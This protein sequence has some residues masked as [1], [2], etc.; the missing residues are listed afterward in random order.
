MQ[1]FQEIFEAKQTTIDDYFRA[2]GRIT[3]GTDHFCSGT[4]LAGFGAHREMHVM[5]SA[6]IP[7][8]DVIRI[9]TINGARALNIDDE[10]FRTT[11]AN[12]NLPNEYQ[13]FGTTYTLGV[14]YAVW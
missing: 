3:L 11:H 12:V 6:G 10:P 7:A 2:G 1:R 13:T 9:A 14:S 5:A 4:H 8:A